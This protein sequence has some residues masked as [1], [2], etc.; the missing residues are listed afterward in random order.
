MR[1]NRFLTLCALVLVALSAAAQSPEAIRE[2]LAKYPKLTNPTHSTYPSIP[3]GEV[4]AAPEGFEPFYFTLVGRH[5]SRYEQSIKRFRKAV[6]TFA[7]AD[8]LGILTLD[9]KLL[10]QRMKAIYN[11]QKGHDGELTQLGVEQWRGISGRAYE[12]FRNI[13]ENGTIEAKSSTSLRCVFSMVA[14]NEKMKELCPQVNIQQTARKCDQWIVRPLVDD[15]SVS[16]DAR[17]LHKEHVDNGEWN[18][19][20]KKWERS[21]DAPEFVAKVTTDREAFLKECGAKNNFRIARYSFITLNFGDNFELGD[22]EL[23]KRLY[24]VDELYNMYVYNVASWTNGSVGRGNDMAEMRQSHMR[25]MIEDIVSKCDEAI[26][27]KNPA[28]A[29]LRFTHD[30]YVGPLL[31]AIGYDGCVPKYSDD[32]ET[33]STSF[34]HGMNVPMAANLQIILYRN[35]KGEVLVRSLLNER[36]ATLPIK[37]NTA[38]FYPWKDFCKHLQNNMDYLDKA[39]ERVLKNNGY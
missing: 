25:S 1:I 11:E 4:A 36:D 33:T 28:T 13:F 35:K 34:N 12:R 26:K 30:S 32:I 15:P 17:R 14:F 2:S 10:Y 20:R 8:S 9:G 16:K 27:G 24:T 21:C 37:C 18:K 31:S 19:A 23:L 3:L 22:I 29:N 7:K 5:G 39:Q 38:P 6:S